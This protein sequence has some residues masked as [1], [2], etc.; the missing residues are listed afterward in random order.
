MHHREEC[1]FGLEFQARVH[2]CGEVR[3]RNLSIW[4]HHVNSQYQSEV[5]VSMLPPCSL[6]ARFL[7]ATSHGL[8]FRVGLPTSIY[9]QGTPNTQTHPQAIP[10]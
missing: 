1:L 6:S 10:Q 3:G 4:L 9:R 7:H 5:S 2:C 8:S